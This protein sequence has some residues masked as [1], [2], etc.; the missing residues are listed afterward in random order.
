MKKNT[1]IAIIVIVILIVAVMI[2]YNSTKEL[3]IEEM[4]EQIVELESQQGRLG[5]LSLLGNDSEPWCNGA[6]IN[7]DGYVSFDDFIILKNNYGRIGCNQTNFW[8]I[9]ADMNEDSYV[10]FND[11]ISL[12]INYARSDC[13]G[14]MEITRSI[15]NV[16]D[17]Y[18]VDLAI[19]IDEDA[20]LNAFIISEYYPFG[21]EVLSASHEGVYDGSRLNM[22]A[23]EWVGSEFTELEVSDG[24]VNY[25]VRKIGEDNSF[26]GGWITTTP[27]GEGEIE[28]V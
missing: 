20:G 12:K 23:I 13:V 21:W 1:K 10:N 26:S 18:S 15:S 17:V 25:K 27:E 6:D 11:F 22:S 4:E 24:V 3:T 8:C 9:G 28:N 19:D 14:A 7:E 2:Y 16:G 5:S